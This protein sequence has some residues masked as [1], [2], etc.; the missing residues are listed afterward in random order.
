MIY[1]K[2]KSCCPSLSEHQKKTYLINESAI[3]QIACPFTF[4]NHIETNEC[5]LHNKYK[6]KR[7]LHN[8]KN[9]KIIN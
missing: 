3:S 1:R 6:I 8:K 5:I 9:V 2:N 7:V 4:L